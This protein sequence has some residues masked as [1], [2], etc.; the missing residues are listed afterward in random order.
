LINLR[1]TSDARAHFWLDPDSEKEFWDFSFDEMAKHDI[2]SALKFIKRTRNDAKKID[3]YSFSVGAFPTLMSAAEQSEFSNVD[4]I[5]LISP[6]AHLQH[7][8]N[9]ST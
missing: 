8:T 5:N 7:S 6:V 4:K 1:G 3:L 9:I 2:P